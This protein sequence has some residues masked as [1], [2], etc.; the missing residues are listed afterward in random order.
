MRLVN[1]PMRPV[2][3]GTPTPR[4]V[5]SR[6][7]A[8]RVATSRSAAARFAPRG[9]LPRLAIGILVAVIG[10]SG[11]AGAGEYNRVLDI[12]D[13]APAWKDL[14]DTKGNLQSLGDLHD[15]DAVVVVFTCNSCPYAVDVEDRLISLANEC[16]NRNVAVVAINVNR[17]EADSP[18][19]MKERAEEK[20]F[21]FPYLYDE[22]QQIAKEYGATTTPECYVLDGDRHVAYMGSL[23]DSPDGENV[24][25]R[26]VAKAIDAVLDGKTPE[27]SETVPIGCRIRFERDR[28]RRR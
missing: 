24:T 26:H 20:G 27:L 7:V 25:R 19:A 9:M 14:P 15:H 16:R 6:T 21:T 4:T 5:A 2:A 1:E 18:E 13:P 8:S 12:G 11:P 3:E 10:S 17:V 23:D 28:R 22:S